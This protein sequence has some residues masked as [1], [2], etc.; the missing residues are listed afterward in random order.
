M[1]TL[2]LS[3]V[4]LIMALTACAPSGTSKGIKGNAIVGDYNVNWVEL[5]QSRSGNLTPLIFFFS[6]ANPSQNNNI[7]KADWDREAAR[8]N[9]DLYTLR[10]VMLKGEVYKTKQGNLAGCTYMAIE[11][12]LCGRKLGLSVAERASIA[13]DLLSRDASCKWVGFDAAYNASMSRRAGADNMSL[14]VKADCR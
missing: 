14:H 4:A 12:G 1:R 10:K 6:W 7:T 8:L 5:G 11:K 2:T 9:V 3:L 13:Q